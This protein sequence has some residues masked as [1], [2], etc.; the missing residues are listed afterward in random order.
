MLNDAFQPIKS[1]IDLF[2]K[3]KTLYIF[4]DTVC[5]DSTYTNSIYSNIIIFSNLHTETSHA[6][7]HKAPTRSTRAYKTKHR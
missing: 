1:F 6:Q 5:L 3:G 4:T 2:T 7:T